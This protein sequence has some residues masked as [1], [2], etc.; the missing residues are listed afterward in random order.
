MNRNPFCRALALLLMLLCDLCLRALATAMLT[1]W[2]LPI[3]L[4]ALHVKLSPVVP[5]I[6]ATSA[7][8]VVIVGFVL[9]PLTDPKMAEIH[10]TPWA[11][12]R[13]SWVW[14]AQIIGGLAFFTWLACRIAS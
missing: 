11:A 12:M 3:A 2:M 10:P 4:V 9:V 5:P 1:V 13:V 7:A 6:M 8:A 14:L